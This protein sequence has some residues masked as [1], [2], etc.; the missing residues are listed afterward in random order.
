MSF[1]WSVWDELGHQVGAQ[2]KNEPSEEVHTSVWSHQEK[3]SVQT[4]NT[5]EISSLL[6]VLGIL[7]CSQHRGA[8]GRGSSVDLCLCSDCFSLMSHS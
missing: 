7:R 5:L 6:V 4:Q 1:L 2:R 3:G 8:A